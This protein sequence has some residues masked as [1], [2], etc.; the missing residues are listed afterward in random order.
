[1]PEA[2]GV[3]IVGCGNIADAYVRHMLNAAEIRV[4]GVTDLLAERAAALA[5]S[6]GLDVYG[7]LDELLADERVQ[8]VANLT[9]HHAHYEVTRRCLEA[10]KHVYSEK[11]LAMRAEEARELTALAKSSGL[12]LA[13]API[14]FMGEAQ[15]TAW[16]IIREG[17]LGPV[18]AVYAEVDWGRIET[19]H[20]NPEPFYEVG[21]LFDVG[22]YPLTLLTTIL[23]PARR[24][25]AFGRLLKP[26]RVRKDGEPY[27]VTTA[28]FMVLMVDFESGPVLRLTANFY[29][30][31]R[32]QEAGITFHG[33]DGSLRLGNWFMYDAPVAFAPYGEAYE[34]APLVRPAPPGVEWQRGIVDMVEAIG[35]ERP[36]RATGEQAAHVVEIMC[37]ALDSID[38]QSPVSI[39]STFQPPAPM[40]WALADSEAR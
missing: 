6:Y 31:Q 16:K 17:R 5:E 27:Q 38:S 25:S 18:R 12:R 28:D 24:V 21:P 33:D 4:V 34:A 19:W 36:Q 37:A 3:G 10:G 30:S 20:P 8:I 14:T 39:S 32:T 2:M 1:M 15:Q 22:V 23:G 26:G 35:Q 13:C 11:P 29:V 9:I 40:A 7:S